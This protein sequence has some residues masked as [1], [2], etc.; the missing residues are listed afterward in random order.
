MTCKDMILKYVR[1]NIPA[2]PKHMFD[3]VQVFYPPEKVRKDLWTLIEEG[4]LR[5]LSDFLLMP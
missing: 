5:L 1:A 4:Q 3:T 2:S